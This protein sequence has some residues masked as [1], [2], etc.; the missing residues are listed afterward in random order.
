MCE[1]AFKN[2]I[3]IAIVVKDIS[4]AVEAWSKILG[5]K[6]QRITETREWEETKMSFM[7]APS[8]GRAK[9]AF[10]NLNNI[11]I[12]LIEPIDGPSTWREF[13]DKHGQGIHHI[14]FDISGNADCIKKILEIGGYMQQSGMFSG[15]RYT[16][17]D[18]REVLGAIIELIEH[19]ER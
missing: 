12:E 5:M 10:F 3:Q 4:K 1:E 16:Y 15:G 19:Y 13:L 14:A 2:V 7:G 9:L 11:V 17:I 6:P 18:A 8:K